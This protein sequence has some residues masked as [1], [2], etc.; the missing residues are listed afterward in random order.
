MTA[1]TRRVRTVAPDQVVG[2]TAVGALGCGLVLTL[3]GAF[4]GDPVT[5]VAGG[6]LAGTGLMVL[7]TAGW[8]DPLVVLVLALS[9]PAL[10]Q[11]ETVRLTM[12]APISTAVL[13]SWVLDVGATRRRPDLSGT[14]LR[15][16]IALLLAFAVA[17]AFARA[18]VSGAR[19]TLN[20]AVVLGL[21]FAATD[22]LRQG[23]D[24]VRLVRVVVAVAAVNSVLAVLVSTGV[25]PGAFPR[26]GTAFNRAALGF[27][28][29][30]SLGLFL[31]VCL[32]LAV[33]ER[34]S[35][36]GRIERWAAGAAV[37]TIASGLLATFSR[38]SWLAFLAGSSVLLLVG[39]RRTFGRLWVAM[40]AFI[41]LVDVGTG[42]MLRTII[43]LTIS[44]WVV[45]QRFAL[46]TAGVLMFLESPLLGVG[47]GGFAE[48]L[49]AVSAQV[50]RLWDLQ[51][52]PHNAFVQAAAESGIIGL[53]AFIVFLGA[54]LHAVVRA[55]RSR[56]SHGSGPDRDRR[57]AAAWAFTTAVLAGFV[58]WPLRHGTGQLMMI[59]LALALAAGPQPLG[60]RQ[61]R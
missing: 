13:L 11:T 9:M 40:L 17:S 50:T 37:A 15:S 42:G 35:A 39:E 36:R 6:G 54:A 19:E 47:P 24:R 58:G 56:T 44:D 28:Q 32:P 26:V 8:L 18:P 2:A 45:E 38:G 21:A 25:V 46:M 31:A 20:V 51:P 23:G 10:V 7:F 4:R 16:A 41:V 43:E 1:L 5:M 52:T 12:A 33:G 27:G 49:E 60:S 53:L 29:P 55:A 3:D 34:W 14:P 57:N 61:D 30:N 22:F 48:S 59:V